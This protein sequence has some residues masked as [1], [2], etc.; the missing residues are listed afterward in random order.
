L[1][2]GTKTNFT[3]NIFKENMEKVKALKEVFGI[4]E[5]YLETLL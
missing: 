1:I 4:K 5:H 2:V 3:E